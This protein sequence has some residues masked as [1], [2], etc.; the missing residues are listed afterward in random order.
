M[1]A[2]PHLA[3][4]VLAEILA[5]LKAI[6]GVLEARQQRARPVLRAQDVEAL[7]A[8]L[9]V[10]AGRYGSGSFAV[11]EVMEGARERS[12]AGADLRVV[13]GPRKAQSLGRLLERAVGHVIGGRSVERVGDAD[14]CALWRLVGN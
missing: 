9:P 8:I 4:T 1:S 14:G 3:E 5:E 2:R 10:L 11:A 12:P 6:R 13:L 7:T